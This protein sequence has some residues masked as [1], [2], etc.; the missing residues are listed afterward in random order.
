MLICGNIWGCD[1]LTIDFFAPNTH[2]KDLY[3]HKGYRENIVSLFKH[4]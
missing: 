3:L 1:F 2:A 4:C